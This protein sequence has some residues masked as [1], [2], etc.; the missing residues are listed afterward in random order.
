MNGEESTSTVAVVDACGGAGATRLTVE[1]AA[2]LARAGRSVAV[3][4]VAVGTQGLARHVPGHVDPDLTR[5]LLD[6]DHSLADARVHL[7]LDLPGRVVAVPARAPFERFARAG[8]ADAA[9]S[10]T[11]L[12][13]RAA[14]RFDHVLVDA[15]PVTTNLAV[16]AVTDVDRVA[17]VAPPDARGADAVQRVRGRLADVGAPAP[18][19]VVNE[20][21]GGVDDRLDADVRVP[22]SD[23]RAPSNVPAVVDP[24]ATFAPAVARLVET[25]VG[26]ELDLS[27]P[28][29]GLL[30]GIV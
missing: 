20:G 2:T 30:E 25:V 3:L 24:D 1:V 8:T 13:A 18:V 22:E 6:A 23:V 11:D 14:G 7:D 12:L 21:V 17:L 27:F 4:D 28:E 15:P 29:E 26:C 9:R 19:V 5:V 16:A 10:L